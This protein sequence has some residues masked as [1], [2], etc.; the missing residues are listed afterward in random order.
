M[1]S[2]NAEVLEPAL[3]ELG[4]LAEG[5]AATAAQSAD[6][7]AA[8]NA[9][10]D[11]WELERLTVYTITRTP[12]ALV[13]SDGEYTV[14]AGGDIPIARPPSIDRVNLVDTA[15]DPDR[16]TPLYKFTDNEW[17]LAQKGETAEHPSGWHYEPTYPLGTLRLLS[18]PTGSDLSIAVYALTAVPQ[19]A[20][21]ATAVSLPPGYKRMLVKNLAVEL[22]PQFGRQVPRELVA[23]AAD[24]K[25]AVK[26]SN[27][28]PV[29][30]Q[31]G[32]DVP[33]VSGG[34]GY[35]ISAG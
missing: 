22:G 6:A 20:S 10:L 27:V 9:L 29:R 28:R 14:G 12:E 4:V 30:L 35:D 5:E 3:R 2:V 11:Q 19:F 8:L 31:F 18:I 13:P 17:Q 24:A 21:A 23:Q 32:A 1:G 25:G 15:A 7:L 26:R 33:G 34:G 16:E